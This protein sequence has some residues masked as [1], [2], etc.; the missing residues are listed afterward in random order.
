MADAAHPRGGDGEPRRGLIAWC[1]YDWA[2]S[3]FPTVVST[4]VF[5]TYFATAVAPDPTT[6]TVWWGQA[7][8]AAGLVIALL[9]PLAGAIADAAGPRK[10]PLALFSLIAI[11]ATAGLWFVTPDASDALLAL[12]LVAVATVGFEL[13]MVFY[14]AMLPDLARPDR[15]GRWSGWGWGLGYGGGL[16][17][18]AIALFGFIQNETPPFGLDPAGAEPVRATMVV[19]AVW[20][21]VFSIPVFRFVPETGTRAGAALGVAT[22]QGLARLW[23]TLRG[24]RQN[25]QVLRFL[26]ARLVYTDGLN[27]LFAFGGIYAAGTF[28][29]A[30][31][32]VIL[33][34]IALNIAAG[35]GAASF[36]WIDDRFGARSTVLTGIFAIVLIGI[37]LL[38]VESK[39][40]FWILGLAISVFFGPVQ[41][42]SR[43]LMSHLAPADRRAE[44]F[45]LYALSGKITAFAGPALLAL[46]T[47][48][49]QSQRAGMATVVAM[50]AV[51]GLLLMTV[52]EPRRPASG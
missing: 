35:L 11:L 17:C 31:E 3:A 45:G 51:G 14:N 6:G 7:Q 16:A 5:A 10:P 23:A 2:N 22:R 44:M 50:M 48:L 41:A 37:P 20:F 19:V 21:L 24:L 43:S 26:L 34:G 30:L 39:T 42:A 4:F 32:E 33:F 28:G 15:I 9:A 27:T 29:L 1:F 25:T 40:W 18:L 38:V 46:V 47:A 49:F 12:G 8:A 36:A 13:G 52:K